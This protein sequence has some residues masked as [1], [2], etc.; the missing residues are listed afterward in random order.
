LQ[1]Q[2]LELFLHGTENRAGRIEQAHNE[3]ESRLTRTDSRGGAG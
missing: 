2:W 1:S 3:K